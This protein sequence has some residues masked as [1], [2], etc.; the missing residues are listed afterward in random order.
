MEEQ[1]NNID[2]LLAQELTPVAEQPVEAPPEVPASESETSGEENVS[3]ETSDLEVSSQ[4]IQDKAEDHSEL[5]ENTDEYGNPQEPARTYTEDEV[6]DRINKAVRER[7]ARFERKQRP[8]QDPHMSTQGQDRA[9]SA[10][11]AEQPW[12]HQLEQFVESTV[13]KMSQKQQQEQHRYREQ[14]AQQQFEEKFHDGMSRFDDFVEVVSAQPVSDAMT[15]G[16]RSMKDPAAFLYAASKSQPGE[17]QKISHLPDPYAQ[18]AAIARLEERLKKPKG[19][20]QAPKPVS[21]T[22]GD[23]SM[24]YKEN[25]DSALD[26]P[27]S[28]I[29]A[30]RLSRMKATSRR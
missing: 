23:A 25:K 24:P 27:L 22:Q 16:L 1:S 12:E 18:I 14:Q 13:S 15:M 19:S 10:E 6:N 20:T 17:L 9:P 29:D 21:R 7:L 3:R 8:A 11:N 4:E 2:D 30:Q 28:Q 26:T 5:T